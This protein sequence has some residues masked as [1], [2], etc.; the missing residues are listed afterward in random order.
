MR[1][2]PLILLEV[3][4]AVVAAAVGGG[5]IGLRGSAGASAMVAFW[6]E[7]HCLLESP[8][9]HAAQPEKSVVHCIVLHET[10]YTIC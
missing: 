3:A 1:G 2:F 10:P 9:P 5:S 4:A 7:D 8:A 6:A